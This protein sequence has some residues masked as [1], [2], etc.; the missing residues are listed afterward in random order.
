[1]LRRVGG[2]DAAALIAELNAPA[3]AGAQAGVNRY[4]HDLWRRRPD[5]QAAYTDLDGIG[6]EGL[7]RWAYTSGRYECTIPDAVMP[8]APAGWE[9]PAAPPPPAG[10]GVNVCGYL[11][12]S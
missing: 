4:L 8:P 1:M 10:A 3:E 2:R 5:L 7:V 6:G 12:G 11:R 9:T